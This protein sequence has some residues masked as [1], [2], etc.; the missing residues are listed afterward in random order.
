MPACMAAILIERT[1]P[2]QTLATIGGDMQRKELVTGPR[3][4][5]CRYGVPPAILVCLNGGQVLEVAGDVH[6][7][8][9]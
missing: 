3:C 5:P 4:T 2:T 7:A 1:K 9:S 6:D 8:P